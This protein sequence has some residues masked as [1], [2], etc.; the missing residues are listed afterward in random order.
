MNI[1]D[2]VKKNKD[3]SFSELEFNEIDNVIFSQIVYLPFKNIIPEDGTTLHDAAIKLN[4]NYDNIAVKGMV[5]FIKKAFRMINIIKD[6]KRYK[7][8]ILSNYVKVVK[9]DRQFGALKI[10]FDKNV[11]VCFEGTDETIVGWQE[12]FRM[13]YKYPIPSQVMAKDYLNRVID[14]PYRYV[15]VG[16]H[17]KGGN[18][19]VYAAMN[20]R[21]PIRI[22]IKRI[23][24]NDG[25][26]FSKKVVKSLKYKY[27][28]RKVKRFLPSE[29]IVGVLLYHNDNLCTI[30]SN[31][32][33]VFQ[34]D[35]FN[36]QIKNNHFIEK[37]LSKRSIRLSKEINDIFTNMPNEDLEKFFDDLFLQFNESNIIKTPDMLKI[38]RSLELFNRIRKMD[39]DLK[40]KFAKVFTFRILF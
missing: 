5:Y 38:K 2:Y 7:D 16:G 14:R 24:N 1:I 23:F 26:G 31:K 35:V 10:E 8:I 15:Y 21:L 17:S 19:A 29:S 28:A 32:I 39:N 40:S 36:W 25:P 4:S 3:K 20:A 33:G 9:S 37:P 22:K 13:A 27:I 34:H 12:D 11:Y 18:L 6:S 30:K